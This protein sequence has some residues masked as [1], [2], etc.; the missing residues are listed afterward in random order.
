MEK[1]KS[2]EGKKKS[3]R[4]L[5]LFSFPDRESPGIRCQMTARSAR[6]FRAKAEIIFLRQEMGVSG[7][8]NGKPPIPQAATHRQT[9]S[10][11]EASAAGICGGSGCASDLKADPL[12]STFPSAIFSF[13][14]RIVNFKDFYGRISHFTK[15]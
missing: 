11:C 15:K 9:V 14:E 13:W 8:S 7:R 12:L 1:K 5:R 4:M 6:S 3:K 10:C 2:K